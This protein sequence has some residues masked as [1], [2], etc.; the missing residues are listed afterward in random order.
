[1]RFIRALP[2]LFG[3]QETRKQT[4]GNMLIFPG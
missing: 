2:S 3:K 4:A 1:M